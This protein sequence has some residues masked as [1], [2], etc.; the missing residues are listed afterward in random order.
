MDNKN[1][2]LF[3]LRKTTDKP[4]REMG[5]YELALNNCYIKDRQAYYRDF[6]GEHDAHVLIREIAEKLGITLYA[7]DNDILD[8]TLFDWLERLHCAVGRGRRH[9]GSAPLPRTRISVSEKIVTVRRNRRAAKD[10]VEV[11]T[12]VMGWIAQHKETIK[13]LERLLG[14]MRKI[15]NKH[16]GRFYIPRTDALD[17]IRETENNK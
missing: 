6:E 13:S 9:A 15:E 8:F 12:P 10:R 3:S 17:G 11:L 2:T 7:G 4:I 1:N 5:M 14:E 16:V